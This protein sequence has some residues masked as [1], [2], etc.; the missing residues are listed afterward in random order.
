MTPIR[1]KILQMSRDVK[2]GGLNPKMLFIGGTY[3]KDLADDLRESGVYDVIS[4]VP[5]NIRPTTV[6]GMV[7]VNGGSSNVLAI[8]GDGLA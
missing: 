1:E 4:E 3:L 7:V 6:Y 2:K 5:L 8:I